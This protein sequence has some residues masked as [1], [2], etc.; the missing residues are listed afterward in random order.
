MS[1]CE[2]CSCSKCLPRP[3]KKSELLQIRMTPTMLAKI[4]KKARNLDRTVASLMI[5]ILND[6][7]RK[8]GPLN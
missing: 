7:M 5:E 6:E 4:H 2:N 8:W 3:E 1:S